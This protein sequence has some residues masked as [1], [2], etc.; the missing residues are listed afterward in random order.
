MMSE[1]K[2][3]Q[4]VNTMDTGGGGGGN[5]KMMH[6]T[7][8]TKDNYLSWKEMLEM[9]LEMAGLKEAMIS[10]TVDKLVN[11]QARFAILGSMDESH[12]TQ[13][14]GISSSVAIMKHL[15]E[16]YADSSD[17]NRYR[18]MRKYFR[19]N[20]DPKDTMA[21]HIG[22]MTSMKGELADL[23]EVISDGMFH[24]LLMG[25]LPAEYA[26][27]CENWE[28]S[29]ISMRTTANL[30]SRL[31]KKYNDLKE[32]P[33]SK[34]QAFI[35][36]RQQRDFKSMS[37]EEKKKITKCKVCNKKGHWARECPDK[38]DES[39]PSIESG[40]ERSVIRAN[41]LFNVA[42]LDPKFK[43][44]W[45]ADTGASAHMCNNAD[46]FEYYL[47]CKDE[48]SEYAHVYFLKM[49]SETVNALNQ[50]L[51]E[52]ELESGEAIRVIQSD[53]G[54][55]F[56]NSRSN[57]LF[58]RERI[59]HQTTAIYTPQQNGLIE[60]EIQS[61]TNTARTML[62]SS[63]LP[64]ELWPEAIEEACYTRN[65]HTTSRSKLTPFERFTGRVPSLAHVIKFGTEV[66]VIKNGH[67]L[68]KFDPRTERGFVVGHTLRRNTYK[69]YLCD[70]RRVIETSDLIIVEP[71]N[72]TIPSDPPSIP[73]E[74][75][76]RLDLPTYASG[77]QDQP[78]NSDSN[79]SIQRNDAEV[80]S[81][82][83]NEPY[84]TINEPSPPMTSS[85][86]RK[87]KKQLVTGE[88]LDD[89][90]R[91]YYDKQ[92]ENDENEAG[93]SATESGLQVSGGVLTSSDDS[94]I[95]LPEQQS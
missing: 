28:A 52:S 95:S 72:K 82:S 88:R 80:G 63:N 50:L 26:N 42:P 16:T 39:K 59:L 34:N 45:L 49:K 64:T 14:R 8:V 60:R 15:A 33:E 71:T 6:S 30:T 10:E 65:R 68:T 92:P 13:V 89:F 23:G 84:L 24:S 35:M 17:S 12:R 94:T 7:S 91:S 77:S 66:Q 62:L 21:E 20:K 29:H 27:L 19:I 61:I 67:Y 93:R 36:T 51:I 90:F 9:A 69:V 11:I 81:Q 3:Q 22:K 40:K 56:V 73:E 79:N 32:D 86:L 54:S 74:A 47:V 85:T 48:A 4:Q 2:N 83:T 43:D 78:E 38:P 70:A 1:S 76:V 75:A 44:Y 87:E 53:N 46:W 57:M 25:S 55:E 41:V 37:I 5:N 18:L 31:M 58:A